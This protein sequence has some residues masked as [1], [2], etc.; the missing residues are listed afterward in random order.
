MGWVDHRLERILSRRIVGKN[1][2]STHFYQSSEY[3][4]S[5]LLLFRRLFLKM[6][7]CICP[8]WTKRDCPFSTIKRSRFS[9]FQNAH[10]WLFK[11]A[12]GQ[13]KWWKT[14]FI[15][16]SEQIKDIN[17]V[18]MKLRYRECVH[19]FQLLRALILIEKWK[20]GQMIESLTQKQRD[21]FFSIWEWNSNSKNDVLF[22]FYKT[23]SSRMSSMLSKKL[24]WSP[25]AWSG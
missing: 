18:D 4:L 5:F 22:D 16:R 21:L 2:R 7:N 9:K 20:M 1:K 14:Q 24:D 25:R 8:F 11:N 3:V 13:I 12:F 23:T 10:F 19:Q 6:W 17:L 15:Y